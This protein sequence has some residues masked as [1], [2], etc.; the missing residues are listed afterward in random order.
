MTPKVAGR[1][2]TV[3]AWKPPVPGV[4]EVL[5]ARH[6]EH[7]YPAH[8][9]DV[10][11]LFVVDEGGIRYDLD[12]RTQAAEPSMVSILPPYVVH[13]GRPATGDGY[14]KRVIYIDPEIIGEGLIGAAVNRP[15]LSDPAL[16]QA[17][18]ALDD[19]LVCI[20]DAFEAETRLHLVAERIRA[21]MGDVDQL[22]ERRDGRATDAA[23]EA[24]RAYLDAHLFEPV[25]IA[26]AAES[27]GMAPTHLARGFK[28]TFGIAPHA[29]VVA[30]RLEVA[31][32]RILEGQPLADVATEV[33]FFDQ[34]HL[35]RRFKRFLGVTPGRFPMPNEDGDSRPSE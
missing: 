29:Y 17:V 1:L 19:A 34:A 9:H 12:Q 35:T 15:A 8:T 16:R 23:V 6:V 5:H 31:R 27:L 25:T 28:A 13:D 3:R 22:E 10:W 33:G 2:D 21:A 20:D 32:D 24:F 11:T 7:T 14:R 4:R 26:A 18:S 30:R